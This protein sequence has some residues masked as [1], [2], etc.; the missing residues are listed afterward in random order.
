VKLLELI[1]SHV[2]ELIVTERV[3]RLGNL[4][5]VLFDEGCTIVIEMDETNEW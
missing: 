2:R 3:G 1:M 4:I 5:I